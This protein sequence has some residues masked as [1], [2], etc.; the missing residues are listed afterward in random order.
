MRSKGQGNYYF[1]KKSGRWIWTMRYTDRS[2]CPR[3]KKIT[4]KQLEVLTSKVNKYLHQTADNF[5]DENVSVEQWAC[6]FLRS[7]KAAW[8]GRTYYNYRAILRRY[9]VPTYRKRKIKEIRP[10]EL[11]QWYQELL[12][13]P[14]SISTVLTIRRVMEV[15]MSAA[16]RNGLI[17]QNPVKL[18]RPP[19]NPKKPIK[20]MSITDMERILAA[21]WNHIDDNASDYRVRYNS[22]RNY[23]FIYI[24]AMTGCRADE[25]TAL[26]WSDWTGDVLQITHSVSL[27]GEGKKIITDPKSDTSS[28]ILKLDSQ[29]VAVLRAWQQY[30]YCWRMRVGN[31]YSDQNLI[32][33]NAAGGIMST[34]NFIRRYW[35]PL[36]ASLGLPPMGIHSLRK[37]HAS[38]LAQQGV[39][40]PAIAARLG[41]ADCTVLERYYLAPVVN[42]NEI[43]A[44]IEQFWDKKKGQ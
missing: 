41:H 39:A 36:L 25:L 22:H 43:I 37:Y 2:G 30:Q 27:T 35:H 3:R 31:Y 12:A 34:T 8:K 33:S 11:E 28:R 44:A 17:D 13:T 6:I 7:G 18:S 9:I 10:F 29:S 14:L 42:Q 23:A 19:R 26:R 16:V 20:V 15:M 38:F 21:A 40:L 5:I 1:D 32:F 4:S 24:A